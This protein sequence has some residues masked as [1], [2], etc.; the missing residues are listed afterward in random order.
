MEEM[1]GNNI[2]QILLH[3]QNANK[4]VKQSTK[5]LRENPGR[6]F[7]KLISDERE[8][9]KKTVQAQWLTRR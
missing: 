4:S 8:F 9:K 3:T 6:Y 2:G 5:R 7:E 1:C